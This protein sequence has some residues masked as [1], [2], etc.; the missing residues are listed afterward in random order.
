M[1][2]LPF[3]ESI[4]IGQGHISYNSNTPGIDALYS[5]RF[6]LKDD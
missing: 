2:A 1:T 6:R 4:N 3:L 5:G